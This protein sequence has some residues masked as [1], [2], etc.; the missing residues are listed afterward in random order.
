MKRNFKQIFITAKVSDLYDPI[1][2]FQNRLQNIINP[3]SNF[4]SSQRLLIN[5]VCFIILENVHS[6]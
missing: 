5:V 3:E 2:D 4:Q 6:K 1:L